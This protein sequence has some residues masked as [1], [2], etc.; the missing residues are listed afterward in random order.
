MTHCNV[1]PTDRGLRLIV[2]I[3]LIGYGTYLAGTTGIVMGVV[4]LIPLITGL[5]G[6]CPAYSLFKINTCR[7]N[8]PV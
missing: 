8:H 4:G 6:R 3:I 7:T 5:A 1:G 2:G